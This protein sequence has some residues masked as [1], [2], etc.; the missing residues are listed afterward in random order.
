MLDFSAYEMAQLRAT[1]EAAFP[2]R[3]TVKRRR[4]SSDGFGGV[5]TETPVVVA[6]E[7]PARITQAQVQDMGGQ[8]ARGLLLE[9]WTIRVPHGTDLRDEDYVEWGDLTIQV[10]DVKHRSYE[11]AVSAMGE[12][13]K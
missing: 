6:M 12:V 9:K 10:E 11:T 8:A 13:V 5:K 3:V 1:Q 4:L 7:V 2:E